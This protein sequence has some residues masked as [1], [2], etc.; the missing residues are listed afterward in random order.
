MGNLM[1]N[2][3]CQYRA[4]IMTLCELCTKS[5]FLNSSQT[6]RMITYLPAS[7]R[8]LL[9]PNSKLKAYAQFRTPKKFTLACLLDV[10]SNSDVYCLCYAKFHYLHLWNCSIISFVWQVASSI[11]LFLRLFR[12]QG[13]SSN[14]AEWSGII[15]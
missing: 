9:I 3:G 15:S 12:K 11:L 6:C 7:Q 13:I 2:F 5:S 10:L 1:F 8:C 4:L 14:R